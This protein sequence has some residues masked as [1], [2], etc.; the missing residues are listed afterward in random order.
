MAMKDGFPYV[1]PM[2]L[3]M[4]TDYIFAIGAGRKVYFYSSKKIRVPAS[5][6][7]PIPN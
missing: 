2:N 4:R 3:D 1:V 7:V 5:L 6:F